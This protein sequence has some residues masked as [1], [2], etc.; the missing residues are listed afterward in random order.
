MCV[1]EKGGEVVNVFLR[2][3]KCGKAATRFFKCPLKTH[4]G[5]PRKMVTDKL[6]SYGLARHELLPDTF[7]HVSR[8]ANNRAQF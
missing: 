4:G 6:G 8:Y 1:V 2:A 5:E 7:H 3:R